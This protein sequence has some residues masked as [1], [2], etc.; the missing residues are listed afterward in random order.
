VVIARCPKRA[1]T[2]LL[3]GE[4]LV[5]HVVVRRL[6]SGDLGSV[7][8]LFRGA[9]GLEQARC[10]RLHADQLPTGGLGRTTGWLRC[11]NYTVRIE[12]SRRG[13]AEGMIGG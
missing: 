13:V 10:G 4:E 7:G 3:L 11:R 8:D 5:A 2:A 1:A 9:E 12:M 6:E